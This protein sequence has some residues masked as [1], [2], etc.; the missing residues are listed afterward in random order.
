MRFIPVTLLSVVSLFILSGCLSHPSMYKA[1]GAFLIIDA[2]PLS[3]L[4]ESAKVEVALIYNDN[5][6]KSEVIEENGYLPYHYELPVDAGKQ[7][8]VKTIKVAVSIGAERVLEG[9]KTVSSIDDA[10]VALH[11][12]SEDVLANTYWRAEDIS[13]RGIPPSI[14]TTL[15]F[16]GSNRLSGYAGCNLYQ[17]AYTSLSVFLEIDK[18]RLTRQ[19]CSSPIMYH[20]NRYLALLTS[21]EY[22]SIDE[23]GNLAIYLSER[24]KPLKFTPLTYQEAQQSMILQ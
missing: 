20:E 8:S 3:H 5:S 22:F 19:R 13:G 10:P 11:A 21:A 23:Q 7:P 15:I 17:S 2:Q 6:V 12:L 1:D 16:N 4:P 9:E 14:D 18:A 24:E